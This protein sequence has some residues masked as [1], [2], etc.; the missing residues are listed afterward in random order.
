MHLRFRMADICRAALFLSFAALSWAQT[1]TGSI[2][3]RVVDATGAAVPAALVAITNSDTT[4]TRS[5]TTS[6]AGAFIFTNVEPGDY[7]LTVKATGFK[8]LDKTGLHLSAS[9]ELAA[10]DLQLQVGNAS[11]KVEVRANAGAV[12]TQSGDRSGL[13]DSKQIGDLMARGRDV[14]A[15]LQILPGVVN[16]ATGSDVLGQFSTPTMDGTRSYYNSLNIDGISGNTARGRTAEAPI[17]L[18]AIAEVKVL[19]NS[20][21]A[22]FGTASGGVINLVTKNGTQRFHGGLY[23]YS[24]NEDFNANNFFNNRQGVARQRYRYNT[25]G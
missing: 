25:T 20:Y 7:S 15:L 24:R 21:T 3:G 14:M 9:A 16:D 10:G 2:S 4:D 12:E 18:D 6:P 1:S 5:A 8:Q 23:Y 19:T 11:E 22:E 17:N 13:I